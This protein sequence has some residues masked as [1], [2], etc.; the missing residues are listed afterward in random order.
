MLQASRKKPGVRRVAGDIRALTGAAG[1]RYA[2]YR[3]AAG[4]AALLPVPDAR[5]G[6]AGGRGGKPKASE[7]AKKYQRAL[8]LTGN[9][10]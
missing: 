8:G 9:K 1:L 3:A 10:R 4:A 2:E 6:L 5:S 7:A